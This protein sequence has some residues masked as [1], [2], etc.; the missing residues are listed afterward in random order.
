MRACLAGALLAACATAPA[1]QEPKNEPV[2]VPALEGE[3]FIAVSAN[4][5]ALRWKLAG[6]IEER[7]VSTLRDP[8]DM[9]RVRYSVNVAEC[10]ALKQVALVLDLEKLDGPAR[11][12]VPYRE[13][14]DCDGFLRELAEAIAKAFGPAQ[15]R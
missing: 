2:V 1:K 10:S 13:S 9:G 4:D 7:G 12:A 6:L 14:A 8:K 5:D 3:P 11:V 15:A